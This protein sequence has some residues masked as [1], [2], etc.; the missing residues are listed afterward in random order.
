MTDGAKEERSIQRQTNIYLTAKNGRLDVTKEVD[1]AGRRK[2]D[3]DIDWVP[4]V[5]GLVPEMLAAER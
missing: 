3:K 5:I 1:R 2:G 4:T